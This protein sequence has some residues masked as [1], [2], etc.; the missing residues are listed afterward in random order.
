MNK[1]SP[2]SAFLAAFLIG[3]L[4]LASAMR[5]G[6]VQV[7]SASDA[8]LPT[9]LWKSNL[10]YAAGA[11]FS[12]REWSS[13]T[14]ADGVVYI[15]SKVIVYTGPYDG[16]SW[17]SVYAFNANNGD[18]VWEY[19][20]NSTYG[21]SP[22]TVS[23]GVVFFGM[24][25]YVGALDA[26]SGALLWKRIM[27]GTVKSSPTVVNGVVY[28]G[29]APTPL[30]GGV[31]ALNATNGDEIWNYPI[32]GGVYV[33]PE[34]AEGVVYVGSRL[35]Y[36]IYALNAANGER[37]W[38]Y[39]AEG[40]VMSSPVIAGGVVYICA[41]NNVYALSTATGTKIW[42]YTIGSGRIAFVN[43]V[44]Y[45]TSGAKVYALRAATGTK[46]WNYTIGSGRSYFAVVG[47]VVYNHFLGHMI[48]ADT[49]DDSYLIALNAYTGEK[50]WTYPT[51]G[52]GPPAV[53]NG[54]LYFGSPDVGKGDPDP[55]K[56]I[57]FSGQVYA[58]SVPPEPQPIDIIAP[59][60]SVFSPENKTYYATSISLNFTVNELNTQMRYSLDNQA[61]VD[62]EGNST[63]TGLSLGPHNLTVYAADIAGNMGVSQT[64]H[65]TV[66]ES[67]PVVLVAA[68]SAV[69]AI[70]VGAGLLLY[71]K[72]RKH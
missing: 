2:L 23:D 39:T 72:K 15:C 65:F 33:S 32:Y 54:V 47:G 63:L 28:L 41:D 55:S 60:I 59:Q 70:A 16:Y 9:L 5:F 36:N 4:V 35:D 68:A 57:T 37:L 46:I 42:N 38:N 67:F 20:D 25:S 43:S 51:G 26:S 53:A 24:G 44:V 61:A 58:I 17:S 45:V 12:V 6:T 71:F 1:K 48:D 22:P 21:I 13:P 3:G 14:V 18:L 64:I 69:V 49:S 10:S 62:I 66:A 50:L 29:S 27:N 40:A 52:G 8:S 56:W 34:V 11:R 19:K 31:Y 30:D 7:A